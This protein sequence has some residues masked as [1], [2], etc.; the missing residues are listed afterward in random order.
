MTDHER[1]LL[2]VL[3]VAAFVAVVVAVVAWV[4]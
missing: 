3:W 1:K 4:G 2:A